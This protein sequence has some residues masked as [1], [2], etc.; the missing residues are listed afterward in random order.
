MPSHSLVSLTRAARGSSLLAVVP[1]CFK[2]ELIRWDK[3]P[4][5]PTDQPQHGGRVTA[6]YLNSDWVPFDTAEW[7]TRLNDP[8]LQA[9]MKT[10]GEMYLPINPNGTHAS[11]Q[12]DLRM[13]VHGF[14]SRFRANPTP[15]TQ[16]RFEQPKDGF[17][18][19]NDTRANYACCETVDMKQW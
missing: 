2:I 15:T 4:K 6:V 7:R 13:R 8:D 19:N 5:R 18:R 1:Y 11:P 3:V 17:A 10:S 16:E 12:Q 9:K 14:V